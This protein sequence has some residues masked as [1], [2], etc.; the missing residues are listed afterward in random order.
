MA[1]D[2]IK[3][4]KLWI[5][6]PEPDPL[7][8][9]K[10]TDELRIHPAFARLLAQRVRSLGGERYSNLDIAESARRVIGKDDGILEDPFTLNDMKQAVTR[11]L[12]AVREKE[13]IVIYGDYDVDGVTSTT[14]LL[15][16]LKK[17]GADVD[18]YIPNRS[19][20][21]YGVN[22]AALRQLSEGGTHL[23]ITVDTGITAIDEIAEAAANGL[24]TV[25][26]DHH[27][28]REK[29][30]E[31]CAVVNPRRPDDGC[32][33]KE[34]AGVGVAF[35]LISALEYAR[36]LPE[37]ALDGSTDH[38]KMQ[39]ATAKIAREYGAFVAI[40]TIADVMPLVGENRLIVSYGLML[41]EKTENIGLLALMR[42][43]GVIQT[44]QR[45]LETMK[46]ITSTTVGF[47]LAPR[48]N[49]AGRLASAAIA[50]ELFTTNDKYRASRIAS[51]LCETNRR[52]QDEENRILVEAEAAIPE[53]CSPDDRVLVLAG[54]HWHHG[55]IG[56]VCSRLTE[57]YNKPSILISFEQ[58]TDEANTGNLCN[59]TNAEKYKSDD[60]LGKGSGR[61]VKGFDLVKALAECA[62]SLSNY[63]GHE[64]AAGL[65]LKR[66]QLEGFRRAINDYAREVF[67]VSPEPSIDVDLSLQAG[68]I[69]MRLAE[70]IGLLEP[71]GTSN[72]TPVFVTR[73][74]KISEV[75]PLSGGKHIKMTLSGSGRRFTA[76][77]F[78]RAYDGF[79]HSAG[80]IID[81]AYSLDINRFGGRSEVQMLLRD[82]H[83][84][85]ADKGRGRFVQSAIAA[86]GREIFGK[87]Y[88]FLIRERQNHLIGELT[89]ETGCGETETKRMLDVF[90]EI[91]I[92]EWKNSGNTLEIRLLE[93]SGIK[94][95]E[96]RIYRKWISDAASAAET[97]MA[98]YE[99]NSK[100]DHPG[101]GREI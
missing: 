89:R 47:A 73:G 67:P 62:D 80:D 29:L 4:Q 70:D 81:I 76:L 77:L 91:G 75:I 96:S 44:D 95:E 72:P 8:A 83:D 42:A 27:E 7:E 101:E 39:A 36:D 34:Y 33:F 32:N 24:E 84:G 90:A 13:K 93:P 53:Q 11:I 63:G 6:K 50:V 14:I 30:P 3:Q 61:S 16:Y 5:M 68:E 74:L 98:A 22:A 23:M 79:V 35:K 78:G 85:T 99:R 82:I 40:G 21:G 48:I 88:K 87:L 25:V 49:A 9:K 18:F 41:L 26:T 65:S 51:D 43:A 71:Y 54:E 52:R 38:A 20:E 94:L 28:C 10:L 66:G 60:D 12:R 97:G 1:N 17:L 100:N 69:S 19:G 46:K 31:C 59:T 37:N 92:L 57:K 15:E 58:L 2:P 56:I 45:G 55:V 64:L 86:P